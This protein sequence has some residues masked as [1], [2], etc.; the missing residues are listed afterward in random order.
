[1][2]WRERPF[3]S[4]AAN[5]AGAHAQDGRQSDHT[6]TKRREGQSALA[7]DGRSP[8]PSRAS[9]G[10]WRL[11]EVV[12]RRH[13]CRHMGYPPTPDGAGTATAAR[14]HERTATADWTGPFGR[15]GGTPIP[16]R[17]E[18]PG[19]QRSTTTTVPAI[20]SG[21]VWWRGGTQT[22]SVITSSAAIPH[23]QE[24]NMLMSYFS[25]TFIVPCSCACSS[26]G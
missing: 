13:G 18:A 6:A 15:V 8:L 3:R 2:G 20:R 24:L 4:Q 10:G 17:S 5:A 11:R 22:G 16:E 14:A 7:Q 21:S 26:S 9:A 12:A 1:M 25:Y 23:P 19:V